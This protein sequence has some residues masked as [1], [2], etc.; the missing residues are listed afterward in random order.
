[1]SKLRLQQRTIALLFALIYPTLGVVTL[2]A[3]AQE[4]EPSGNAQTEVNVIK[5][6]AQKTFEPFELKDPATGNPIS[7][8]QKLTL[9]DGRE[10]NA[11]EYYAELNRFEQEF[12]QLGYSLRDKVGER[13]IQES[14]S[15]DQERF[16]PQI[17]KMQEAHQQLDINTINQLRQ[18]FDFNSVQQEV[19]QQVQLEQEILRA[20]DAAKPG[21]VNPG[22]IDPG[23]VFNPRL[24]PAINPAINPS[25]NPA[26]NKIK[27]F[28]IPVKDRIDIRDRFQFSDIV[29]QVAWE[30]QSRDQAKPATYYGERSLW[31]GDKSRFYAYL[32]AR[33]DISAS[34]R[35]TQVNAEGKT[36]AYLFNNHAQMVRATANL[37][38]PDTGDLLARVNVSVLGRSI[39]DRQLKAPKLQYSDSYTIPLNQTIAE[40]R[41]AV[42]PIPMKASFGVRGAVGVRYA[43]AAAPRYAYAKTTPFTNIQVY[44]EGGADIVVGGAGVGVSLTL[45][46]DELE[47]GAKAN[48]RTDFQNRKVFLDTNF[49][50]YNKLDALS[51]N[52]YAYAYIYRPDFGIPPWTKEQ[53]NWTIWN[54]KGFQQEGY[55]F[56][57]N[58]SVALL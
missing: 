18:R 26:I 8:D 55:L 56:N 36:G 19:L 54:W 45:L 41:F 57:V 16:S 22:Q 31:F 52:V 51:G 3:R 1:M 49:Y 23:R 53:W 47:L 11:G 30:Q 12:N 5:G 39:Y 42:G 40:Y 24:N 28:K 32:N 43:L 50:A 29:K 27:Q 21:N 4:E 10:V 2:S 7:A 15:R 34:G 58:E 6:D 9:P 17:Q 38:A 37:Q 25:I 35:A 20:R 48:I 46:N 13:T 33:V 44:G 14:I